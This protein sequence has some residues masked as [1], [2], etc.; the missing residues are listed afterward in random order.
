MKKTAS[1]N[2][3]NLKEMIDRCGMA[4]A[5]DLIGGR[6]KVGILWTLSQER[7]RYVELKERIPLISERML[8]L[9]LKELEQD[10]LVNRIVYAAVPPRVEYELSENGQTLKP[11]L[12]SLSDWGDDQK[13]RVGLPAERCLS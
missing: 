10:G 8:S 1:T 2:N 9:Q 6:W 7:L 3:A 5:L 13:M 11:V 4:Y 12:K